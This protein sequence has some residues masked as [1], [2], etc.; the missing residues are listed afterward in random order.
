MFRCVCCCFSL[1]VVL[2]IVIRCYV[3]L[4]V[5][6][7]L[8]VVC[9]NLFVVRGLVFEVPYSLFLALCL[10]LFLFHCRCLL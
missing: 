5:V 4:C 1:F 7:L 9:C 2:F 8:Y 6:V 3:L 10:L